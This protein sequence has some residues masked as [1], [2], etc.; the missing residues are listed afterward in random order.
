MIINTKIFLIFLIILFA[1]SNAYAFK[2][3]ENRILNSNFEN[4]KIGE[5]PA[6]WNFLSGG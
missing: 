1:I 4:D 3:G 2:K 6:Y 5:R